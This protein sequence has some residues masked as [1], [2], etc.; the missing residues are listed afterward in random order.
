M[1]ASLTKR[2]QALAEI[3]S[4]VAAAARWSSVAESAQRELAELEGS[5]GQAL[6]DGGDEA[7]SSLGA[8]INDLRARGRLA[9]TAAAEAQRRAQVARVAALR[10]EAA[11]LQPALTKARKAVAAHE[12][13]TGELL[14]ALEE[15]TGASYRQTT[16]EDELRSAPEGASLTFQRPVLEMLQEAVQ[17]LEWHQAILLAVA[18]GRDPGTVVPPEALVDLPNSVHPDRGILPAR[19]VSSPADAAADVSREREQAQARVD[20]LTERVDHLE[21]AVEG[22]DPIAAGN[23]AAELPG[24]HKALDDAIQER[25]HC[26]EALRGLSLE[27]A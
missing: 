24:A 22:L 17:R 13:R 27:V 21:S 2:E 11:E 9:L 14:A 4:N 16:W 23:A 10:A 3:E 6:L 8:K 19:G 20:E 18:D 5:A 25:D 26:D 12:T 1:A 7:A 15:F